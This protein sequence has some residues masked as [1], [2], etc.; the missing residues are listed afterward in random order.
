[1]KKVTL[2]E[3]IKEL[4]S[5]NEYKSKTFF[6]EKL[7]VSTKTISNYLSEM[8]EILT[9]F[10]LSID[11]Q[12]RQGILLTGT[13]ENKQKLLDTFEQPLDSESTSKRRITILERLLMFDQT[14]SIRNLSDELYVS[15]SSISRDLKFIEDSIK[16]QELY[17]EKDNSGT[18]LTGKE[19]RIRSAKREFI[20]Y[21][22]SEYQYSGLEI[23]KNILSEYVDKDSQTIAEEMIQMAI[24]SLNFE[25]DDAY[26]LNIFITYSIFIQRLKDNHCITVST[27]R[28]VSTELHK[29]RTYPT[30]L[31]IVEFLKE[32]YHFQINENDIRW[33]NARL[34]GV[35]HENT[36]HYQAYPEEIYNTV[37]QMTT[38]I[39]DVLN[40][41]L[42]NDKQLLENLSHHFVPLISRLKNN[43]RISNP[44]NQEIKQQFPAMFS[45]ITLA[46]GILENRYNVTMSDNEIS[47]ILIHYQ[48]ALES[49]NL[50]KKILITH[51]CPVSNAILIKNRIKSIIPAFDVLEMT[52][53]KE[54]SEKFLNKFDLIVSTKDLHD[55]GNVTKPIA[56]ISPIAT[57]FDMNHVKEIYDSLITKHKQT[58]FH[59]LINAIN[60]DT[61]ILDQNFSNKI[62][63]LDF[64]NQL[65]LKKGAITEEFQSTVLNRENVAPTEIGN[66][67]A[68]PHGKDKYVKKTSIVLV[69]L[70]K[71]IVWKNQEVDTVIYLAVSLLEKQQTKDLLKNLYGLI[72]NKE[73]LRQIKQAKKANDIIKILE[74]YEN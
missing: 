5:Q 33:M 46:C 18:K 56:I 11:S 29:L 8:D 9:T 39:G 10:Y 37:L 20:Y 66:M 42:T 35:Y 50:S 7:G 41:D 68:I 74:E 59:T 22:L 61:I 2:N 63:I 6:A 36:T 31:D 4:C 40:T 38:Y 47:F 67:I 12:R 52:T 30:I 60:E 15:A 25:L 62:E 70:N 53:I 73:L 16:S 69:R 51:D 54:A 13:N 26:H 32:K 65:L 49:H 28:P 27:I 71:P 19:Q 3:F 57:K 58:K 44:F 34:A 43:I 21:R 23:A 64:C 17:Y 48:A 45:I 55:Y 14:V 24:R 72:S 1:M